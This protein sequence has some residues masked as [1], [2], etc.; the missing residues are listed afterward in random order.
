MRCAYAPGFTRCRTCRPSRAPRHLMARCF[1][2]Q[3]TKIASS[4]VA[5]GSWSSD[6]ARQVWISSIGQCKLQTQLLSRSRYEDRFPCFHERGGGSVCSRCLSATPRLPAGL[7][8]SAVRRLGRGAARHPHRQLVRALVRAL[9]AAQASPQVESD[10]L[11]HPSR[12]LAHHWLFRRVGPVGRR[13]RRGE[14]G[15]SYPVQVDRCAAVHEPAGEAG[16]LAPSSVG[17][18]GSAAQAGG[19]GH[20]YV[21]GSCTDRREDCHLH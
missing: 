16:D 8:G 14:A 12:L 2:R 19:Q 5:S 3:S 6:V 21:P 9:V 17:V 4:S 7:P 11:L 13:S 20:H 18:A 15:L 1:T 10:G